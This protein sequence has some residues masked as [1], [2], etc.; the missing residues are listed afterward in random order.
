MTSINI[1]KHLGIDPLNILPA[2]QLQHA[3]YLM[4]FFQYY[5]FYYL[6]R[7][8]MPGHYGLIFGIVLRGND[9]PPNPFQERFS[10]ASSS[11]FKSTIILIL[12]T[13]EAASI[14]LSNDTRTTSIGGHIP[15]ANQAT[16][17]GVSSARAT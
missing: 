6:L 12:A 8:F 13:D 5:D 4:I 9:S 1:V 16:R 7:C 2:R 11:E 17:N 3:V 14:Y 10:L 15:D